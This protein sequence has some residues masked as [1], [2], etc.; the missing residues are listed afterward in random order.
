[1]WHLIKRLFF[2]EING[3]WLFLLLRFLASTN[4]ANFSIFFCNKCIIH[5][6]FVFIPTITPP[7]PWKKENKMHKE[8]E[9][10]VTTLCNC[11]L[12]MQRWMQHLSCRRGMKPNIKKI[13]R[14]QKGITRPWIGPVKSSKIARY[15]PSLSLLSHI[16]LFTLKHYLISWKIPS[17]FRWIC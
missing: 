10:L 12:V 2:Y 1:M 4:S 6:M 16:W 14:H 5:Y 3:Y 8:V 7:P 13:E 17:C 15:V 11:L 9:G